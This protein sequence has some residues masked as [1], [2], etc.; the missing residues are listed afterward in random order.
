MFHIGH[1][2]I[3]TA[4]KKH[5]DYLIVGVST[6]DLIES[7]KGQKPLI[8]YEER[9]LIVESIK[10]VDEV[11]PQVDRDKI[12]TFH[13]LQFDIMFVGDDWKGSPLFEEVGRQLQN[14]GVKV[15][16]FPYTKS[17]SSTSLRKLIQEKIILT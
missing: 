10:Y 14:F 3:L 17:T 8:A 16:Y 5:C 12:K 9:K 13:E 4:A 11:I 2:N 6:D 7:Y 15:Q 1:L